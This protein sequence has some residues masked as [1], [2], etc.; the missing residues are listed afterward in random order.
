METICNSTSSVTLGVTN[1]QSDC[2]QVVSSSQPEG[3]LIQARTM[4]N[5]YLQYGL[6]LVVIF[7]FSFG[8][9]KVLTWRNRVTKIITK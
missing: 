6:D 3:E 5:Y 4:S 7:L 2:I 8:I 9:A 1:V